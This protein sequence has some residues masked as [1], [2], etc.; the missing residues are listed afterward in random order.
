VENTLTLRVERICPRLPFVKS[1]RLQHRSN[2]AHVNC[3][4][5]TSNEIS[6]END[7]RHLV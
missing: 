2:R 6:W 4:S 3:W 1:Q 7:T 5:D